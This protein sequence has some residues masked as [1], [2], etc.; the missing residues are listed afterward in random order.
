MPENPTGQVVFHS[1]RLTKQ[2]V[3]APVEANEAEQAFD[4]LVALKMTTAQVSMHLEA[5]WRAGLFKQLDNLLDAEEWDFSDEMPSVAS[6]STFLRMIIH[7]RVGRRPGLGATV[8]GKII[9]AWTTDSDRLTVECQADDTV[10]WVATKYVNGE[11]VSSA[12]TCPVALLR[13]F[14]APYLPEVWFG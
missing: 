8:D 4:R 9:A 10:R 13:T 5:A 2:I 6:F 1:D 7:N 3:S 14:L 12:N 11:R